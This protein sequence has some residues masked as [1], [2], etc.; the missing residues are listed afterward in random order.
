MT[1][2][3]LISFLILGG[4]GLIVIEIIFV[5]GTTIVGFL[6]F[7]IGCYGIYRSYVLYG[8]TTGHWVLGGSVILT[9]LVTIYGFKSNAWKRFSLEDKIDA[10]VNETLTSKL[11][12]NDLGIAVSSLRP[13]GK[14]EF[15][16]K[17]YEVTT[18]GQ[19]VNEKT[20][21]KIIK[22]DRN[23]IIVEPVT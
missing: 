16:E 13:V 12:I 18:L 6:G 8:M 1:D 15:G 23:K 5:P 14:A 10:R 22:I 21:V 11:A 3:I 19:F 7:G 17:E 20:S 9:L 4:I 2:W